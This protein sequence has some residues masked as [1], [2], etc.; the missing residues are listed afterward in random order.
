MSE[1]IFENQDTLKEIINEMHSSVVAGL[2]TAQ[3]SGGHVS[4]KE[5]VDMTAPSFSQYSK[6]DILTA[7][8]V[9]AINAVIQDLS[10]KGADTDTP[11]PD[12]N[13]VPMAK[14]GQA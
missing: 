9:F 3:L 6:E 14:G 5:I 2:V 8:T 4:V 1:V 13:T 7:F 11:Q 10:H 12:S